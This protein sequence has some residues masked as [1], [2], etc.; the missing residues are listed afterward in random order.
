[1]HLERQARKHIDVGSGCVISRAV[2]KHTSSGDVEWCGAGVD[3]ARFT[4][5][6]PGHVERGNRYAIECGIQRSARPTARRR[7]ARP[8]TPNRHE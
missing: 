5:C 7:Q 6:V 2:I 3:G 1:M 4:A 8:L